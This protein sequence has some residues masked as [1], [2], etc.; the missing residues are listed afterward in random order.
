[1]LLNFYFKGRC[2]HLSSFAAGKLSS[3][4]SIETASEPEISLGTKAKGGQIG[5]N[6]HGTPVTFSH[7]Y[8]EEAPSA[9]KKNGNSGY[10]PVRAISVYI[11]SSA[12]L[13]LL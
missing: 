6:G 13:K 9:G 10:N 11:E 7:H 3:R 12:Y 1:M 8:K 4:S 5:L 2:S